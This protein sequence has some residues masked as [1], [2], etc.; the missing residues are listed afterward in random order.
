MKSNNVVATAE[1]F[2]QSIFLFSKI[3][4]R[5]LS[6]I[7]IPF[8]FITGRNNK[9]ELI[10]VGELACY[11]EM[12]QNDFG[13]L[14]DLWGKD[15]LFVKVIHVSLL[16]IGIFEKLIV[17]GKLEQS[18]LMGD[19]FKRGENTMFVISLSIQLSVA[20]KLFESRHNG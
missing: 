10:T 18:V 14:V 16:Q 19:Y 11:L 2:E 7:D 13:A 5:I 3:R 12:Y 20:I 17:Q 8:I 4:Y 9:G 1:N 6:L 15:N